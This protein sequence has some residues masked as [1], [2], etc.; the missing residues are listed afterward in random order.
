M[1]TWKLNKDPDAVLPYKIDWSAWLAGATI[2]TS[3]WIV[4][5]GLAK[6]SD[7]FTSTIATVVLS[8]GT[9]G[10]TYRV[11]NR[12]TTNDGRTDDRSISLRVVER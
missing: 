6:D 3:S 11:T 4:P 9:A 1:S 5:S 10:E 12:I 8:G 7:S 2:S